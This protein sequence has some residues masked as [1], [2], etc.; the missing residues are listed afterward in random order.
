MVDAWAPIADAPNP[1][2]DN[3]AAWL[4]GKIYT[5]G[6][7]DS[8]NLTAAMVY[9]PLTGANDQGGNTGGYSLVI[10]PAAPLDTDDQ[11]S[12]ATALGPIAAGTS[13]SSGAQAVE[14]TR[15]FAGAP[16]AT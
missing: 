6:G 11:I 5:V 7:R 4:G 13:V 16:R 8:A 2:A 3:A 10:T 9:N 1:T 14:G 12:E 15:A